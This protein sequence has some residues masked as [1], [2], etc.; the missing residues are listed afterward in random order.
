MA[1]AF[2]LDGLGS[3]L[4]ANGPACTLLGLAPA[5]LL[6]KTLL[7]VVPIPERS[8]VSALWE[9]LL[10]EG[11]QKAETQ[12]QTASGE[13]RDVFISARSNL[14]F[15]VHLLVARD[16]TE[17]RSLRAAARAHSV[18]PQ[19]TTPLPAHAALGSLPCEPT[20]AP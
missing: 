13:T 18:H 1:R 2:L 6:G 17:L 5:E 14:W 4:H 3:F 10:I 16:Q 7:E 9:A 8:Q 12:L 19:I 20:Q 15:G 11:Q